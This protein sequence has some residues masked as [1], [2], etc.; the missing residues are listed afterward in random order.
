M[1]WIFLYLPVTQNGQ[2]WTCWCRAPSPLVLRQYSRYGSFHVQPWFGFLHPL[3]LPYHL[4]LS[5]KLYVHHPWYMKT[6]RLT[7]SAAYWHCWDAQAHQEKKTHTSL[8]SRRQT[9][10]SPAFELLPPLHQL[11]KPFFKWTAS[12]RR[13]KKKN[14]RSCHKSWNTWTPHPPSPADHG[15]CCFLLVYAT[16]KKADFVLTVLQCFVVCLFVCFLLQW[17]HYVCVIV[18]FWVAS[19]RHTAPCR[20]GCR[21]AKTP[22]IIS[23]W[24]QKTKKK[25][26]LVFS[27]I[28]VCNCIDLGG[29]EHP[30]T[31]AASPFP[32]FPACDDDSA[33][34][35][36]LPERPSAVCT[37]SFFHLQRLFFHHSLTENQGRALR[38]CTS[39]LC[40]R[41]PKRAPVK[42]KCSTATLL[43]P[44]S[45]VYIVYDCLYRRSKAFFLKKNNNISTGVTL[46]WGISFF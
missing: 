20:P 35:V 12:N 36:L 40:P 2:N 7:C 4:V 10:W 42:T 13:R 21:R 1:K 39:S 41:S 16:K 33:S 3:P 8:P 38:T 37:D 29:Q 24:I 17:R 14:K 25:P 6:H 32:Y 27:A 15:S 9:D 34:G 5:H 26:F 11:V 46:L 18:L 28:W 43:V 19:G 22:S 44:I 23:F 30:R 31:H 45:D